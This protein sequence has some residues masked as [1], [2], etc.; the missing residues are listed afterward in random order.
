MG[1]PLAV[2]LVED[3][4]DDALLIERCLKRAGY[5]LALTRA[6]SEESMRACLADKAFDVVLSDYTLPGFSCQRALEVL[7]SGNHDIPFIA[8]SGTVSEQAILTM[9]RAG[10]GDYVMKDN[11]A[12][13]PSAVD[14]EIREA[15]G[16]RHRKRLESQLQQAMKMEA[17]GRLA[18]GVAHDFNNL[19]TVIGGF[20]QLALMDENPARAGLEQILLAAERASGL[21]RQLLAFSRQQEM[22]PRVFDLNQLVRDMEKMLSRLIGEDIEVLSR[23]GDETLTVKADPGQ[24]EQVVMNLAVNSR[25]AMPNGGKLILSTSRLTLEGTMATMHGLQP[26]DYCVVSVSDTGAGIPAGVLPHVF[27]P[28]YTTKPEG[29]GTGLGLSTAYGI[30]RQ[31]GGAIHAYSEPGIGTTMTVYLP[32]TGGKA[33]PLMPPTVLSMASGS[34]T[35]LVAEDD[36]TVLQL[37]S[38]SLSASGFKVLQATNGE[39]A[40]D[41]LHAQGPAGVEVLITDVVMPGI[42]GPILAAR[43]SELLPHLKVMFMSGYTEEVIRNYG[44]ARENVAFLQK[45][46]APSELVRKL[47]QLI[48]PE[49][50]PALAGNAQ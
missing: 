29:K 41:L 1:Q 17:I 3:R 26:D 7:R 31:S 21:T 36:A 19:L 34:E 33:E 15:E 10:A 16:R 30:V 2:L 50:L 24:I 48:G 45:P 11:L 6:D 4:E 47:R 42:S 28:F 35:V 9:L 37:V 39:D 49:K 23:I 27:E 8:L 46:F 38:Y 43:A 40:I 5:E 14:R 18:G 22:E 32:A 44:I 25:D 13:L 20:A 12:R